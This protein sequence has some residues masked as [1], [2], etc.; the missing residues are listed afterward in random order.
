MLLVSSYLSMITINV[1]GLNA[2]I[3]IHGVAEWIKK[4]ESTICCLLETHFSYKDA[5]R[6]KVK[7]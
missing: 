5:H 3:R 6:L 4:E 1:N 7:G 2:S